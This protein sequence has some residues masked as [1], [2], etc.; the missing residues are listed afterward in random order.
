[1]RGQSHLFR[2]SPNFLFSVFLERSN[3]LYVLSKQSLEAFDYICAS[4]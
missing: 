2:G 1:M 3:S 4:K